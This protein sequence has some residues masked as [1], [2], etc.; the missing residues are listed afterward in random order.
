MIKIYNIFLFRDDY[1]INL[2]FVTSIGGIELL[3]SIKNK[4]IT[5]KDVTYLIIEEEG[6]LTYAKNMVNVNN[7]SHI[8]NP[9]TFLDQLLMKADTEKI[10]DGVETVTKVLEYRKR[11]EKT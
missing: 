8:R 11:K 2:L 1:C 10:C 6:Y 5:W 4:W 3:C 7:K 9:V